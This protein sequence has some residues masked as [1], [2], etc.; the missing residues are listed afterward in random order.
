MFIIL[1]QSNFFFN[2]INSQT[3]SLIDLELANW[4]C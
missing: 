3:F 1:I 4:S 2:Y